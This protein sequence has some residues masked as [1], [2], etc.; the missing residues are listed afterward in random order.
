MG[1]VNE[2]DGFYN[3]V[4]EGIQTEEKKFNIDEFVKQK[5]DDIMDQRI[6]IVEAFIAETGLKPSEIEMVETGGA[7]E[8]AW[9]LRKRVE[10]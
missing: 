1:R 5:L 8:R 10:E 2:D 6:K 7:N 4:E 9:F 3:K